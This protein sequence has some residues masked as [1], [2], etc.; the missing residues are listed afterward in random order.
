M[1]LLV[2]PDP[3]YYLKPFSVPIM[4]NRITFQTHVMSLFTWKPIGDI[5][6]NVQ[7]AFFLTTKTLIVTYAV[8]LQKDMKYHKHCLYSMTCVIYSNAK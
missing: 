7:A 6:K 4:K 3:I 1:W 2:F 8:K 5:L